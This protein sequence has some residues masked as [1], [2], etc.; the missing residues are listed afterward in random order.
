[1]MSASTS[2]TSTRP[3]Y[4]RDVYTFYQ[5]GC[6]DGTAGTALVI[7]FVFCFSC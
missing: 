4:V 6:T 3:M 2:I 5:A 7:A 1:M